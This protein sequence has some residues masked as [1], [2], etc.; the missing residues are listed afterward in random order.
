MLQNGVKEEQIITLSLD[1]DENEK[2]WNPTN[3][4]TY[5]K[6]KIINDEDMFYIFL[7][8]AQLAIT[9]EEY[10]NK[11]QRYNKVIQHY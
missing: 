9:K 6:S 11:K 2:Y 5:L 8:E 1:N 10:K 3:L 4:S 7:D